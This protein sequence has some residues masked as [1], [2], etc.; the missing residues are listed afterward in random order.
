MT[1]PPYARWAGR[2]LESQGDD[3]VPGAL[4]DW[5]MKAEA[6]VVRVSRAALAAASG[7]AGG[8]EAAASAV[9][10]GFDLTNTVVMILPR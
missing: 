6:V 7:V 4:E 10:A 1:V 5:I 2:L 3:R 8:I 9:G